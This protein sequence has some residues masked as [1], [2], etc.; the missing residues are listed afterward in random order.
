M[1][2]ITKDNLLQFLEYYHY[3]HD[4]YILNVNYDISNS[5]IEMI[6][7]VVWSGTPILKE[8]NTYQTNKMKMKLI[9][10]GIEKCNIKEVM[11]WDY[12]SEIYM[13]YIEICGKE[14]ICFSTDKT[15]P[16]I[17]ITCD[18]IQYEKIKNTSIVEGKE[19]KDK[20]E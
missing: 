5:K 1:N 3:F 14:Y 17:Y 19:E 4:S 12:I 13:K 2:T 16:L 6:I 18:D 10:N 7:N 8:D 15:E 11:S 9:F 20:N